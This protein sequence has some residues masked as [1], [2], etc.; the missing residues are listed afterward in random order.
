MMPSRKVSIKHDSIPDSE[1]EDLNMADAQFTNIN[2]SKARFHDIN[3]SDAEFMG[4]NMGGATFK[5]IGPMPDKDGKQARQRPVT[6]EE[7]M[8]CDSVFHNVD[9]TN[10]SIVDCDM[11]GMTIDGI[12]VTDLL[13]AWKNRKTAP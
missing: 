2:L 8:L 3:F 9:M 13:A 4:A 1:F 12:L 11:A 5:H 7:A 10:V 6:F